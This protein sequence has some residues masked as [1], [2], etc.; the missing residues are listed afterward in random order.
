MQLCESERN[1]FWSKN[2]KDLYF[3]FFLD[4]YFYM[5]VQL[6][7]FNFRTTFGFEWLLKLD[8]RDKGIILLAFCFAVI[9]LLSFPFTSQLMCQTVAYLGSLF[10][11]SSYLVV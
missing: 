7:K 6:I 10:I 5:T 1:V 8:N 4:S 11:S 2:C 9:V 3:F